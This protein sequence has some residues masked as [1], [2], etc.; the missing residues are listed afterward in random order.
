VNKECSIN[1]CTANVLARGW[2]SKH[3]QRWWAYGDP[4]FLPP[5]TRPVMD[6]LW[7]K[8]SKRGHGG[9]WIW[10]GAVN[11]KGYGVIR[12]EDGRTALVHRVTY[13]DAHGEIPDGLELD[14]LCRVINCVRPSHLD[15]VTHKINSLRSRSIMA[16]NARKTH[17]KH[18]HEFTSENTRINARTGHRAC[19]A[20]IRGRTRA[21]AEG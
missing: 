18:D 8:V 11:N 1:G 20:C 21:A 2:C 15:P 16:A 4:E 17:C 3:Y 7:E 6:R 12:L 9:C 13:V 19:L 5:S 10:L 14:H